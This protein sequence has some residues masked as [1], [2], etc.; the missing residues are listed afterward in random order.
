M[1]CVRCEGEMSF[2]MREKL[3]LGQT[4]VILGD[5]PNLIAGALL[6]NIYVCSECGKVEF[7]MAEP[8]LRDEALPQKKCPRCGTYHDFDYPKCPACKFDYYA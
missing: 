4:G 7:Y 3:Q 1:K 6:V 8:D 2:V 5:L